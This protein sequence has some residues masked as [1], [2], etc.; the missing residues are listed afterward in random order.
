MTSYNRY[1]YVAI[2]AVV[3]ALPAAA[4]T[5]LKG[6][7]TPDQLPVYSKWF[8]GY[9]AANPSVEITYAAV[10]SGHGMLAVMDG[11]ADFAASEGPMTDEDLQTY[12]DKHGFSILHVPALVEAVVP[13]YNIRGLTQELNFTPEGLAGIVLGKIT[14]WNDPVIARANPGTNPPDLPIVVV[15]RSGGRTNHVW[16]DY[17]CKVSPE[18]KSV[19]GAPDDAIRW[20]AGFGLS[21][22]E[23]DEVVG[24]M[25][26]TDG[27]IGFLN[28]PYVLATNLPYG[29]VRNR[30][31]AFVRADLASL[32]AAAAFSA[33]AI[34]GADSRLSITNAPGKMAYPMANFAWLLVPRK[35][36]DSARKQALVGFLRW[37]IAEGQNFVEPV[38]F[39]K[40]PPQVVTR[41]EEALAQIQ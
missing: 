30:S 9:H 34:V 33:K 3:V 1:L 6:A 10:G 38:G 18:W 12:R 13:M 26:Q 28:F 27:S 35:A 41:A 14:N 7:G 22:N 40:L 5:V 17:L 32:T 39:A 31:G 2:L 15:H 4:Q 21:A 24:L 20:P 19:A 23:D 25:K 16:S 8:S 36:V 29:R 37:A 11:T